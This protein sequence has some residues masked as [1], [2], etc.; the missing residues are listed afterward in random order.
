MR[1]AGTALV[2]QGLI[3]LGLLGGAAHAETIDQAARRILAAARDDDP[4]AIGRVAGD[5]TINLWFL[6]EH[7]HGI[8]E[9]PIARR[10]AESAPA[11]PADAALA[12]YERWRSENPV[13][14]EDRQRET[15][16]QAL[17]HRKDLAKALEALRDGAPPGGG[18]TAARWLRTLAVVLD[19][20]KQPRG[21]V[22]QAYLAAASACASIGWHEGAKR[23]L[24]RSLRIAGRA[25]LHAQVLKLAP[26]ALSVAEILADPAF[27]RRIHHTVARSHRAQGHHDAALEH[28]QAALE[29]AAT[30]AERRVSLQLVLIIEI[31]SGLNHAARRHL[32]EMRRLEETSG[33]AGGVAATDVQMASLGTRPW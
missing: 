1:S 4:D 29:R 8:G 28:A 5:T 32:T 7:L 26:K 19:T 27:E 12:G 33:S 3:V 13:A 9:G 24:E 18:V 25:G 31:G 17:W 16:V 20:L 11:R 30:P 14:P 6:V 21:E 10:L 15:D 22:T 23:N 2:L